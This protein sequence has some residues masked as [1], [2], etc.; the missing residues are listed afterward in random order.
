MTST[1][2]NQGIVRY[3]PP[4]ILALIPDYLL[5]PENEDR[6]EDIFNILIAVAQ[7]RFDYD[8]A[9]KVLKCDYYF[10]ENNSCKMVYE[11]YT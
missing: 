2:D 1:E 5:Q 9:C 3:I 4:N 7:G 6:L 11:Y 8:D 10:D